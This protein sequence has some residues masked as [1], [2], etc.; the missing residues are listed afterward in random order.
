MRHLMAVFAFA[1][2]AMAMGNDALRAQTSCIE[3]RV[4]SGNIAVQN[5]RVKLIA[6][7]VEL[8]TFTNLQGFYRVC[9]NPGQYQIIAE[10]GAI[11]TGEPIFLQGVQQ[12]DIQLHR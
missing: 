8:V 12:K 5:A 2:A 10:W 4:L 3:G 6:P 9:G 11:R 1:V 7:G